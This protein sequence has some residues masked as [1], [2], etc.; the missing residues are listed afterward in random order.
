MMGTLKGWMEEEMKGRW[1]KMEERIED[2]MNMIM[3]ELENMRG[4]K[5]ERKD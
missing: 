4:R 2:K 5:E 3:G 1:E